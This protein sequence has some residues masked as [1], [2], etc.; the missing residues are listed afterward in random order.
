[1]QTCELTPAAHDSALARTSHLPHFAAAALALT[2]PQEFA[3][4]TATGFRDTTRIAAGDPSLWTAIFEQNT[5]AM[6]LAIG[7]LEKQ[8]T[9]L[10]KA[11]EHHDSAAL[12]KLLEQAK[13]NREALNASLAPQ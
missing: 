9:A 12:K 10:K 6:L 4:F 7:E 13:T 5:A 1:M 8:F 11:L 3:R 2:L